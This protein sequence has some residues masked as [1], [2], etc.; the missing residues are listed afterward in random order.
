MSKRACLLVV[1][2]I[3]L[4]G[5][6]SKYPLGIPEE[7]WQALSP[8][9]QLEAR[10]KQASL[11]KAQA[12]RRAAEARARE[13]EAKQWLK[14]L[15]AK[16][17]AARYGERVQCVLSPAEAYLA[18][19]WRQVEPVALDIV[20]GMI[21]EFELQEPNTQTFHYSSKA[22]AGFDGQ[23][24]SICPQ[25]EYVQRNASPCAKVLGT[26][27][28]YRKGIKTTIHA[29]DFLRAKI[30]CDLVPGKGM[31]KRLILEK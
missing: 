6:T 2:L 22:Y 24:L 16:R 27:E 4:V 21:L 10:Q 28:Q 12:E 30:E 18:G 25:K 23:T 3:L 29:Q 26:F 31:P 17:E 1:I 14:D 19:S 7:Q 15:E 9:E 11:D 20:K 5:C 8:Q 13:A